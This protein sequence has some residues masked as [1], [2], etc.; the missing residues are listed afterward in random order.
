[1]PEAWWHHATALAAAARG[2][3]ANATPASL[4]VHTNALEATMSTFSPRPQELLRVG[5]AASGAA[6]AGLPWDPASVVYRGGN[7]SVLAMLHELTFCCDALVVMLSALS[8]VAVLATSAR[9]AFAATAINQHWL[10]PYV[11]VPMCGGNKG[12]CGAA[13]AHGGQGAGALPLS[14]YYP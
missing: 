11:H 9:H 8:S 14:P 13:L 6:D 10:T 5:V 2:A 1:M 4:L 7:T 12:A 3:P